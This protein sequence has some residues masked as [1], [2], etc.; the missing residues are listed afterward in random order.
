M[1]QEY[2]EVLDH[3]SSILNKYDGERRA[4]GHQGREAAFHITPVLNSRG[5]L[6]Q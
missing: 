4:L 6:T 1:A 2:Y 5:S 3:C